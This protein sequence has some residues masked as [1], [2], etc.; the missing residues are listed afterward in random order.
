MIPP[1]KCPALLR[2]Q[3]I[4]RILFGTLPPA[5]GFAVVC[6]GFMAACDDEAHPPP[7]DAAVDAAPDASSVG[8]DAGRDAEV[9]AAVPVV[10]PECE[11][12]GC[13]RS[14]DEVGDFSRAELEPYLQPGVAIDNGY[15]VYWIEYVTDGATSLA[16]VTIPYETD[17]PPEG[18]AIAANLHGTTGLDDACSLSRTIAGTGLS[19][20]FGARGMIGVAP[21][22]PGLGTPGLHPY[23]VSRVEGRAALDALRA[24]RDVAAV[25]GVPTSGRVAVAGLSQGG[26][27]ALAAAA[28]HATWAPE[29]DLAAVAASG[30]ATVWEEHW[31]LGVAIDGPHVAYH[32]MTMYA[33]AAH[34]GH[35]GAPLW[36]PDVAAT[37]D[38]V[39]TTRCIFAWQPGDPTVADLLPPHAPDLFD[40]DFLAAYEGGNWGADYA[41]FGA[42]F[43]ANR[44]APYEQTAPVAIWQGDADDTVLEWATA[45]VV[46]SL[47]D[48]GMDVDYRVVPGG[49]HTD[50]AFGFVAEAQLRTDESLD[51]LRARLAAE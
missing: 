42:A 10:D 8:E 22:Y 30:P 11:A 13:L 24:A 3:A 19:G 2:F 49:H 17:A 50:V 29:L 27:A 23:L 46:A 48:A 36:T 35:A 28:E 16:N 37:I 12:N 6:L 32:A 39:M 31:R 47:V 45:E 41:A 51:W 33:W 21:D 9:D 20:L 34:Y 5:S 18:Y 15:S 25:V 43:A 44:V 38:D 26:H 1:P 7:R 4:P 14:L 40:A